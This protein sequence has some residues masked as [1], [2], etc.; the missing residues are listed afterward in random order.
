VQ[1]SSEDQS[2]MTID[3]EL[4]RVPALLEMRQVSFKRLRFGDGWPTAGQ[5]K[6]RAECAKRLRQICAMRGWRCCHEYI[7]L[8]R[9]D[10]NTLRISSTSIW[11]DACQPGRV[12]KPVV[13]ELRPLF[14]ETK[15]PSWDIECCCNSKPAFI[16]RAAALGF[17]E[18]TER[19]GKAG[20][21]HPV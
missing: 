19:V 11:L 9:Q 12:E 18:K 1:L 20:Q 6:E 5:Y 21:E 8:S 7:S 13:A 14:P 10:A 15:D 4:G 2:G 17:F 16:C 3:E